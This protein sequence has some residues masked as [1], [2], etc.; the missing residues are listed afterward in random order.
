MYSHFIVLQKPASRASTRNRRGAPPVLR[1][2][3]RPPTLA[4]GGTFVANTLILILI[5]IFLVVVLFGGG[6]IFIAWDLISKYI[7][8]QFI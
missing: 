8:H 6:V 2:Q 7:R 4:I 3:A 1:S 5:L